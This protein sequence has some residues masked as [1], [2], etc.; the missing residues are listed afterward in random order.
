MDVCHLLGIEMK[1]D[2]LRAFHTHWDRNPARS[3]LAAGTGIV[4]VLLLEKTALEKEHISSENAANC[5]LVTCHWAC[6]HSSSSSSSTVVLPQV[7]YLSGAGSK[8]WQNCTMRLYQRAVGGPRP[9]IKRASKKRSMRA[10]SSSPARALGGATVSG[11]VAAS[12]STGSSC[13]SSSSTSSA[14]KNAMS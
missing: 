7:M 5:D 12:A 14:S 1:C 3:W 13:N 6:L 10:E 8:K 11:T 4:T 9:Y 2:H